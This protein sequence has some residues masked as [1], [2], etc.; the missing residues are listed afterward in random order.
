M[1]MSEQRVSAKIDSS[2]KK[3]EDLLRELHQQIANTRAEHTKAMKEVEKAK[4]AHAMRIIGLDKG[5]G[6]TRPQLAVDKMLQDALALDYSPKL[7]RAHRSLQPKR[8][9]G[10][11]PR[12]IVVKFHYFQEKVDVLRKS[13]AAGAIFHNRRIHIY[14]DNT[15]SVRAKRAAFNEV[16]GLLRRCPEV[17][18]GILYPAILWITTPG[19]E[20]K[21]LDNASEARAYVMSN[22]QPRDSE[23]E[24][25]MMCIIL[26]LINLTSCVCGTF[27]VNV[28]QT[29]YQAEENHNITLE[30][31]F[32]TKPGSS[33][34][35]LYI[36]CELLTDLRPS[37]LFHLHGGVEVPE[38]QDEQFTGRVQCDKDVLREGRLRLHVSRLRT[39]DSGLYMCEVSTN[40]GSSTATCRLT[41]TGTFVV[42]V[43]QTSYQA[44]EN[45]NIT[46]EWMFT[47]KPG[48]S[49]H[50]LYI[51]CELLT[52]LRPS[53][54]FHLHGGVE[55]PESQDEQFTGR[56]QCDKDVLREGRLRLH[57]SR[58][59][60]DDS[61]LYM[62]EVFTH[63]GGSTAT[64]RLNV[65]DHQSCFIYMKV[66]RSQSLRMNS[67]QDES[68]V[69]K[70]S[71]EGGR[72]RLHV[73]RLRTDDSGLYMCEVS[74]RYGG[75]T[76]T[77]R[78]TVTG[79][80]VVNVTQ[81]SYQAEENHNITLEWM[82][83]TKPG[84]S[85]HSLYIYCELLTDLR[86]SVLF[87]LHEGVEIPE[88][89]DEQFTGR[90][91][92]DKDVLRE[93]RLRL[94]VSRLRTDDSGLYMCE[95][96]TRYGG[97]TATCR[98]TVT[99][100]DVLRLRQQICHK[101]TNIHNILL[102]ILKLQP[103]STTVNML[104]EKMMCIILLLINLTSCVC[105][106]FVV[107]V[108]QTSYQA[109]ENHNI[110]LEWMFTTKPGSSLHSL[111]IYCELL[112]DLRASV[113]FHLHEG[114]EVPESQDEQF[115]GR[116]QCDKDVLR[117]G[118]LRLHVSR[119]RTDDSGLYMCEV[120]TRYGGST[121][122]CR[123]TV[124]AAADE[125]KPQR[126]TESPQPESP[127]PESPQPDG[128]GRIGLYVGL[129]LIA[130]LIVCTIF[131]VKVY[132]NKCTD[133]KENDASTDTEVTRETTHE[134]VQDPVRTFV[135]NVTQT[136]YQAEENHN[137]TLEWMFTTKPGSSL[138]SLYIYCQLKTDLRPSG[139]F[140]LHGGVEV[141]ESQDEQFTGRVQCD[142]DVLREGRLRLHVSRLRTDDS[143]LYMCQVFTGDGGSTAT[144]R[145]TVTAADEPKPQR[146]T[147][148]GGGIGLYSGLGPP[149][150]ALLTVCITLCAVIVCF[151]IY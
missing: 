59:R 49:L 82:F 97:S 40:Y 66:L 68:S 29:S 114:V 24:E 130:L 144:C 13:A 72:L 95:V 78:L 15:P 128:R 75:S 151:T 9:D 123:L 104:L 74:T 48:S 50:S 18:Y 44:E 8:K 57:V 34:H 10:N 67:L 45:H 133:K 101:F 91:Q 121:A 60:T 1:L 21:S 46:L 120:F 93:G 80:F 65:T 4:A 85:L 36:Y 77:C 137:I 20:Q 54:L 26:L 35:S 33:L 113:L 16:R 116:V 76:A 117:E 28:T 2:N 6:E 51:Y 122:T 136:S 150:A 148:S 86:P 119:L 146:P 19:G 47:T 81:T 5:F 89:Q 31:M 14:A 64:C 99:A 135:V 7:D 11:L 25:K 134:D 30:W 87:H 147:E 55:V 27:V 41:V 71:S 3:V 98:L 70:T 102:A 94:H 61:G 126:P 23:T 58:L 69:T 17:K 92:C 22:L 140:H 73:S 43:T 88:S 132:F 42:N 39:N 38:S 149:V 141:P 111:Y 145:L 62:C 106:T 96:F 127:Q 53:V 32:T 139:L 109:E 118:R 110:T 63:Y 129:G 125:P 112:A 56:V 143:G 142:K 131:A 83:T 108:T 12:P 115:T 52:D 100:A 84:S 37:V 107:N 90:V 124:T 103:T 105:G 79:T 138:H